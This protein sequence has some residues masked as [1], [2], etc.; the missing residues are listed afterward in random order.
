LQFLDLPLQSLLVSLLSVS[1]SNSG[2]PILESLSGLF[3]LDG[4]VQVCVGAVF[5]NYGILKI[6]LF[7]VG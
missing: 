5:V 2:L 1:A 6:L 3:V 4:V 7:L